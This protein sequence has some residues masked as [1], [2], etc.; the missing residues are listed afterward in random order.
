[1]KLE[2]LTIAEIT[3]LPPNK[4]C[5]FWH[6][7]FGGVSGNPSFAPLLALGS[8]CACACSAPLTFASSHQAPRLLLPVQFPHILSKQNHPSRDV[9][10]WRRE[11][12]L[13]PRIGV[14]QT[15]ALPLGYHAM[16]LCA[17]NNNLHHLGQVLDKKRGFTYCLPA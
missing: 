4:K 5:L 14:L 1:M 3:L 8:K 10:I 7:L 6:F 2:L 9:F 15:P 17:D 12:E 13:N 11:W 16:V